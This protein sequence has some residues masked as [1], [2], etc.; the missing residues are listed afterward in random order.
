MATNLTDGSGF[1]WDIQDNGTILNGSIDAYDSGLALNGFGTFTPTLEDAGREVV[2]GPQLVGQVSVSRKVYVPGSGTGFARYLEIITNTGTTATTHTVT[3]STNL[4]SDSSTTVV[5]TSSGDQVFGTNDRWIVTDDNDGTNDPAVVH[6]IRG[7]VGMAPSTVSQSGDQVS[8]SF[9]LNL[10]P[11]ETKII[12]H[13]GVQ[14]TTRAEASAAVTFLNGSPSQ[15]FVGM[16]AQEKAQVVNFAASSVNSTYAIAT[17]ASSTGTEGNTGGKNFQFVVTRTGDRSAPG[18]VDY[19]VSGTGANQANANDFVGGSLP[20]GRLSFAANESSKTI[21]I[22]VLGDTTFEAD[23]SFAVTLRNATAGQVSTTAFKAVGVIRNDDL[24]SLTQ[25]D[26]FWQGTTG[27]NMVAGLGGDDVMYGLDDNDGLSGGAGD[28]MLNG[29]SGNDTL[30]GGSGDDTLYGGSGNDLMY[31]GA[32]PLWPED[33]TQTSAASR[34]IPATGQTLAISLT[35]PRTTSDGSATVQ[36]LVS[37]TAGQSSQFNIVYVID[38]SGSMS[39]SFSGTETV[40]DLNGDGYA[41]TLMDAAIASFEALN[42]SLVTSGFGSSLLGI[43]RFDDT[44]STV[45]NDVLNV[46]RNANSLS[47]A[48]DA[49]RTIRPDGLTYYDLGLQQALNFFQNAPT[50]NNVVF[51]ISDGAPNGGPYVNIVQTL[52]DRSGINASIKAIGLGSGSSLTAL[53]LV[54]DNTAN[55]SAIRVDS[56]SSLTAGLVAPP[57]NSADIARVEIMR[58]GVVVATIMPSQLVSTPLGLQFNASLTG[59]NLDDNSL[60]ARVV[61]NDAAATAVETTLTIGAG[62]ENNYVYAGSGDDTLVGTNGSDLLDG[63]SG[64]DTLDYSAHGRA[65]NVNLNLTTYQDT[66]A[67]LDKLLSIENLIGTRFNDVL[68]GNAAAN[69]LRGGAGNDSLVGNAGN[70]TFVGGAGNDTMIGGSGQDIASYEDAASRVVV[71]LA[72]TGAQN[73]QGGG[74]DTLQV[75]EDLYGSRFNDILTGNATHNALFG[76]VGNDTL[77]GGAGNDTLDGGSGIDSMVGGT[78]NDVYYV[79]NTTDKAVELANE[80]TDTVMSS[81]TWTLGANLENLTLLGSSAINGTGNTLNNRLVGSIARNKLTGGAGNDTLDGG[82]GADTLVGGTGNDVYFVDNPGDQVGELANEGTD[83]VNSII[84]WTLGANIENLVLSGSGAIN[85][86]GNGFNN[87]ITG[88]A[89]A[90]IMRGGAGNDTLLG[91]G[92]NDTLFGGSGNDLL[93]GGAGLDMASYADATSG[94]VVKLAV[95]TVQNTL[96]AGADTLA[97]IENLTGSN[98]NDTLFG[99][100][101]NNL[102]FGN[103]GN[104]VLAGSAGADRLAGGDGND[105]LYGGASNDTLTGGVGADRF[106]FDTAIGASNIDTITDFATGVDKIVLDDDVFTGLTAGTFTSPM[107]RKGAGVTTASTTSQRI[108][109]NTTNGALLYDADGT[110]AA[111]PVQI[112]ALNGA[113]IANVV[114]TDF[115]VVA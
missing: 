66:G 97:N 11:G 98:Y 103:A 23:E 34:V 13:F 2:F 48:A 4:G 106:V 36:G 71:S 20:S 54:D 44:A 81:V 73:T 114:Y 15:M 70:D 107:F 51:F 105:Y 16:S 84:N 96:G 101:S 10:N 91:G 90:N 104:D 102:I 64:R 21:T 8:Y 6:Y 12:M 56:P 78:G 68:T 77:T 3:L 79:D 99:N 5:G 67:G 38:N 26:D 52:I 74:T 109:L 69:V 115:I 110:G 111:A 85:G 88:N 53:D 45:Y 30:A 80:G 22:G 33:D 42:A 7:G 27:R 1:L 113:G 72:V 58:N 17:T 61:A 57:V 89:A 108:I 100:A 9:N 86:T 47:D 75:I 50:G 87:H 39:S 49:L 60:V 94:V 63:G 83:T 32:A 43:V 65:V 59:L 62:S 40:P 76:G 37:R 19:I 46:D 31:A 93:D 25:N 28:D 24:S 29:G 35:A 92:G 95:T 41:N 82:V 55:N 14:R 112:A 18:T